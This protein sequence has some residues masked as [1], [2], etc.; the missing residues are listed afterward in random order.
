MRFRR[1]RSYLSAYSNDELSDRKQ[2]TVREQLAASESLRREEQLFRSMRDAAHEIPELKTSDDFNARL[3]NRIAEERFAETRSK[4]YLPRTTVP[5]PWRRLI[6]AVATVATFLLVSVGIFSGRSIQ[7]QHDSLA[8]AGA[9]QNDLHLTVQPDHN[10]NMQRGF[11]RNVSLRQLVERIDLADQLSSFLANDGF[12]V[13][14]S[15]SP[16][17]FWAASGTIQQ[18]P[19]TMHYH[20]FRPIMRISQPVSAQQEETVY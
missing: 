11:S 5:F 13:A 8:T 17:G 18:M 9:N 12:F 16:N 19:Y 6:P 3:L 15:P 7:N 4:A 10:P 14:S 20:S 1:I 2:N